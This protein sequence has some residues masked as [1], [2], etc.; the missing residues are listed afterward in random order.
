MTEEL[1]K[2]EGRFS[3]IN[4]SQKLVISLIGGLVIGLLYSQTSW[5]IRLLLSWDV[6]SLLLIC[7][8]WAG[9]FTT[10]SG[11][12]RNQATKQD[13][14]RLVSFVFILVAATLSLMGIGLMLIHKGGGANRPNWVPVFSLI[15]IC[16]SWIL[17]HTL[18]T[19]RYAHLYYRNKST[20][21]EKSGLVFPGD[22]HPDFFDFAYFSFVVGMTFQVS[23][24]NIIS[25]K[26]RKVALIH[27]ILSFMFNSFIVALLINLIAGF[28]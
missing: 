24:V 3:R 27:G 10:P 19:L 13:E 2:M 23:D 14:S 9:F 18:F 28:L 20:S 22:D 25:K 1:K 12:T 8:I 6:T 4:A 17:I 15:S 21:T 7:L 5:V 26:I 16:I 11:Q